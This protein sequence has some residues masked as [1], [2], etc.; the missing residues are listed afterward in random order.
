[1]LVVGTSGIVYPVAGFPEV[2]RRAG[3]RIVEVNPEETPITALADLFLKGAAG[4]VLPRL[5]DRIA[6]LRSA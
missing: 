3:A 5:V 2:A 4:E 6:R 1:M